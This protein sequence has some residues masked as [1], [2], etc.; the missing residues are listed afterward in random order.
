MHIYIKK[1][2]NPILKIAVDKCYRKEPFQHERKR[3]EY[4]F[5]VYE[6]YT[7]GLL[8]VEIAKRNGKNK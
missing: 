3:I 1:I 6:K 2:A 8:A 7:G 5:E 4:L